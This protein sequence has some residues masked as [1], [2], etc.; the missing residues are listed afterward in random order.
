MLVTTPLVTGLKLTR[1]HLQAK[2]LL[3]EKYVYDRDWAWSVGEGS[4]STV[5][6]VIRT[7]RPNTINYVTFPLLNPVSF[8]VSTQSSS[9]NCCHCTKDAQMQSFISRLALVTLAST[10]ILADV[11]IFGVPAIIKPGQPFNATF[12]YADEQPNQNT[13]F[14]GYWPYDDNT[15]AVDMPQHNTVGIGM[16]TVSL[17]GL[18]FPSRFT[19]RRVLLYK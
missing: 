17:S 18:L 6:A 3:R 10:S 5:H 9:L 1:D 12:E 2:R 4:T 7:P 19:I 14:W 15:G 16:V 11:A 8:P 13:V